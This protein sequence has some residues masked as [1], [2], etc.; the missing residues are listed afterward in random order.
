MTLFALLLASASSAQLV[1]TSGGRRVFDREPDSAET[2]CLG[3]SYGAA[4]AIGDD[5]GL[6]GMYAASDALTQHCRAGIGIDSALRF[7]DAI[8]FHA[9]RDDGSWSRG[10]NVVDRTHLDWMNDADFLAANLQTF[11]GHVASPS[12]VRRDGRWFMA[13]AVSLDDRN[14]CA[15]EHYAGN[16]C[17]SCLDP[18]SYFVIV[19]AVSDDGINWRIRERAPGDPTFL[20]RPPTDAERIAASNYKGLTRLSLLSQ[21]GYF[22]VAAQYWARTSIKVALFRIAYDAASEWG[23]AGEPQAWSPRRRAWVAADAYLDDAL[24][25][26]LFPYSASF[27]SIVR[28]RVF[29]DERWVAFNPE[30]FGNRIDYQT[31]RNLVDWTPPVVLRSSIPFFADGFGYQTSVIDPVAVDG[32]DGKLHLFFAS[33]DGDPD[34]GMA[35]D[36]HH[37]CGIYASFGPTAPYLG[38]GIY[39]SVVELRA[40]RPT[41]TV[42][43]APRL[44]HYDVRVMGWDGTPA[45]GNVVVA[46]SAG[47]FRIAPLAGGV[48]SVDLPLPAAGDHWLSAWY[49]AQGQWDASRSAVILQRVPIPPRRRATQ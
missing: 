5:G 39:E 48:A 7:G 33:A 35:R 32:A 29:G 10:V 23:A 38:T 1:I 30:A 15:G 19:W 6:V 13:F 16:G 49:D 47:G 44:G 17:G 42:L 2:N 36:G 27:G 18:W 22:Y 9:L 34:H 37:D 43:S 12:V 21:D 46:D 45:E 41:F 24:E 31:S 40:L 8:Q 26:S 28:T 20:G 25:P 3:W 14:L 4:P 11:A